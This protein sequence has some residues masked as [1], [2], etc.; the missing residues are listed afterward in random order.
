[1]AVSHA[2]TKIS[3]D[4]QSEHR[5]RGQCLPDLR[6]IQIARAQENSGTSLIWSVHE[7][8]SL[9]STTVLKVPSSGSVPNELKRYLD[10]PP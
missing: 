1:M 5:R 8:L 2:I 9:W 7:N 6:T 3:N 10:Q 4:I